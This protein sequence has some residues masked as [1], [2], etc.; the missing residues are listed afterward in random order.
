MADERISDADGHVAG[1][2]DRWLGMEL[3][4]LA[5]LAAVAREG[6]FGQAAAS[7][8]YVQSA[9]SQ[10]I[11]R[12][13]R[14]VGLRLVERRRGV[15][16]L[17]LTEAGELLV[18]H[19]DQMES[20]L[21]AARADLAVFQQGSAP[22]LRVGA[23]E[24][25][26]TRVLPR[27]FR[28]LE[29]RHAD[30]VVETTESPIDSD[31]VDRV[32]RGELDAS[33]GELPVPAGPFA[34]CELFRDP[35]VLVVPAES[36]LA[37]RQDA[38]TLTEVAELSLVGHP[39]WRFNDLIEA[40]FRARGLEPS[41]AVFAESNSATQALVSSGLAAAAIMPRLAV[42]TSEHRSI[43]VLDLEPAIPPRTLILYWHARRS[44]GEALDA[45]REAVLDAC[46][47]TFAADMA[48][49][50]GRR[51]VHAR[52]PSSALFARPAP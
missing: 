44:H 40:E 20:Q 4:H 10:Q 13:E 30:V 47:E 46:A 12:L 34:A 17:A 49:A 21:G 1:S 8:G 38:I 43:A 33:F 28:L 18:R 14:T 27:A 23:F 7:L 9:V 50:D 2:V 22:T 52:G 31:L 29:R 36:E 3:R 37:T 35:C 19:F 42:E 32:S 24:S 26:V 41:Y 5:A 48:T 11:A 39:T 15:G 45:F 51:R 16:R 25:I 6:S